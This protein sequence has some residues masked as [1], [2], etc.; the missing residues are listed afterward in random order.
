[1]A[2]Q[3][4]ELERLRAQVAAQERDVEAL[5]ARSAEVVERAGRGTR[6]LDELGI[7]LNRVVARPGVEQ[8]RGA[9]RGARQ[10]VRLVQARVVR[11]ARRR[12][13]GR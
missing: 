9:F 3:A 6:R 5:E 2:N 11:P 7:E 12:L 8:A 10:A 4:A 13:R 1:V